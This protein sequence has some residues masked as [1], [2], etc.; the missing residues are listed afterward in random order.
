MKRIAIALSGM[1]LAT[2]AGL[3]GLPPAS[4]GTSAISSTS[5]VE[6]TVEIYAAV[7]RQ[8]VSSAAGRTVRVYV[9]DGPVDGAE[10]PMRPLNEQRPTVAFD[11]RPSH[12]VDRPRSLDADLRGGQERFRHR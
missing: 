11:P 12:E 7:I 9:I 10:D 6:R 8:L 1:C 5:R 4:G 2:A 3:A